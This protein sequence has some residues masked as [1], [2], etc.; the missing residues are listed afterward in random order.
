MNKKL[1]KEFL[2]IIGFKADDFEWNYIRDRHDLSVWWLKNEKK[3]YEC[4]PRTKVHIDYLR[5]WQKTKL[6]AEYFAK[7]GKPE[8]V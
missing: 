2:T 4:L 1:V 6:E 3:I 7:L 5:F 8:Y